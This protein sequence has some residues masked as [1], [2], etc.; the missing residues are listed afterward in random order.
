MRHAN[1]GYNHDEFLPM[2][3]DRDLWSAL[4]FM[5]FLISYRSSTASIHRA[6]LGS[7]A[8]LEL[9]TLLLFLTQQKAGS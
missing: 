6:V 8:I 4:S 7:F 1:Q 3:G 9:A 5:S 2:K